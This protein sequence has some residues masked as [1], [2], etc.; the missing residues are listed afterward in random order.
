MNDTPS[1]LGRGWSFPPTF[2]HGGVRMTDDEDDIQASL[3]I[4]FGTAP[5]ERFL[6]PRYG[7]DIRELMFEPFSTTLRSVLKDRIQTTVLVYEPRIRLLAVDVD[8]SQLQDGQIL[9]RLDYQVRS[10]NSRFNLVF[11]F[12]QGEATEAARVAG[13]R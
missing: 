4:L 11:P 5:G 7:L 13:R 2:N 1:F 8:D 10:T 3:Q 12:Y 9:L 6:Q